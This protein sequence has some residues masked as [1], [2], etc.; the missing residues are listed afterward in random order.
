MAH[1]VLGNNQAA[2][3]AMLVAVAVSGGNRFVLRA[4]SRFHVL[5]EDLDA[6]RNVLISDT[7]R[8]LKDPWLMAAEIA[9]TELAGQPLR[10]A[11]RGRRLLEADVQARHVSELA[12]ALATAELKAGNVKQARRLFTQALQDPTENSLAQAEWS[13]GQGLNVLQVVKEEPILSF[14]AKALHALRNGEFDVAMNQTQLWQA[15]QPFALDPALHLSYIASTLFER[16][17]LAILACER[18]LKANPGDKTLLNNLAFSQA[19]AGLVDAARATM[20][21]LAISD[22]DPRNELTWTATRGLI[23]FR[24]SRAAEGRRLYRE[25]ILGWQHLPG[26]HDYAAKAAIFWAREEIRA[27][28]E[29]SR[30]ALGVADALVSRASEDADVKLLHERLGNPSGNT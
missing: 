9:I 17:D 22:A 5:E 20:S 10:Y 14:E 7:D 26:S 27:D 25:S 18:G 19:N 24:E 1:T 12:A 6:A 23:A 16:Y 4:A 8:L 13:V 3:K 29:Y 2:S 15:D 21:R 11:R 30:E 28:T